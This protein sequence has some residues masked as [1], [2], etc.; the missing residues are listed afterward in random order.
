VVG[1]H[2]GI[3]DSGISDQMKNKASFTEGPDA[4]PSDR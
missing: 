4:P 2:A 1:G 3:R